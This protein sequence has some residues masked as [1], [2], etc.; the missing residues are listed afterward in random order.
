MLSGELLLT[1]LA[2]INRNR[3]NVQVYLASGAVY[4]GVDRVAS[5]GDDEVFRVQ[6]GQISSVSY[7]DPLPVSNSHNLPPL[8]HLDNSDLN[9]F[10]HD[11]WTGK[12]FVG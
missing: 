7:L 10:G 4:V 2:F 1:T 6:V 9:P 5:R 12:N 8:A 3:L 11:I